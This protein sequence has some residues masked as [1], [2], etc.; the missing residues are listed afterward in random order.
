[1]EKTFDRE[2][3]GEA[4]RCREQNRVAAGKAEVA[5][6]AYLKVCRRRRLMCG[7]EVEMTT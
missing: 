7:K 4:W 5:S 2:E 3:E 1:M 6:P